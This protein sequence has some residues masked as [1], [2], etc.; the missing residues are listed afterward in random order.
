MKKAARIK[1]AP[2]TKCDV[3]GWKYVNAYVEPDSAGQ[4]VCFCCRDR[5][6]REQEAAS[7]DSPSTKAQI[8]LI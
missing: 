2:S 1:D 8:G 3:C 7:G 5:I 4:M 6:E